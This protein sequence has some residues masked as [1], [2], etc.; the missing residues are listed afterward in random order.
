VDL[1]APQ[2]QV[3]LRGGSEGP[4]QQ[5]PG[6]ALVRGEAQIG[7][8]LT[9]R[10]GYLRK[11]AGGMNPDQLAA[12]RKVLAMQDYALILGMPGTGGPGR[13]G[14]GLRCR[15]CCIPQLGKGWC[16]EGVGGGGG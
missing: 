1:A 10:N 4:S 3:L 2:Q 8:V 12:V 9:Q 11:A 13:G 15:S 16:P 7:V 6:E 5:A 14:G